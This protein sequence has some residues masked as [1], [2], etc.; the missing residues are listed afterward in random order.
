M[1]FQ[2]SKLQITEPKYWSNFTSMDHLAAM[3]NYQPEY[4]NQT[5]EYLYDVNY[6][7]NFGSMI[8][9]LPV[10]YIDNGEMNYRWAM[11]GGEERPIPLVKA[12][13]DAAGT[14]LNA[15]D[16][17]G[18]YGASFYMWFAEPYFTAT[19]TLLGSKPE[20]YVIR[21][22]S[23]AIQIGDLYRHEVELL[24]SNQAFFVPVADL[25]ADSL[26]NEGWGQVEQA[27]SKRGNG[28]HHGTHF[29][30]ENT[31][32][33]IRKNYEVP[34]NVLRNGTQNNPLAFAFKDLETGQT[35]KKWI[36]K[37]AWD[38]YRQFRNDAYRLDLYGKSNKQLDGSY[39][40]KG[41]SGNVIKSGFGL[42]EQMNNS[43]ILY[44]NKFSID[45]LL[46][47]VL[48]VTV[49]KFRE[50]QRKL[51]VTCGEYGAVQFHKAL[52]AKPG[53]S[54]FFR[55]DY[56]LEKAANGKLGWN[57]G[58]FTTIKWVNGIEITLVIDSQKDSPFHTLKHPDGGNVASYIYDIFDF[59]QTNGQA[60]IMRV[61]Q[62]NFEETFGYI[63]GMFDPFTPGGK[64]GNP[65]TIT[66]SV[67]GYS[68][69][70]WKQRGI[71]IKNPLKTGRFIPAIYR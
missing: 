31:L 30:F 55:S 58:Q 41:E 7:Y 25:V 68:V 53:A 50:D 10:H 18:Q 6:G 60:N 27:L 65:K 47:F 5:L 49:G 35:S 46:D 61:M 48:S 67:D 70:G 36:D 43:N 63:P 23:D 28:I 13:L 11:I 64:A 3:G 69:Y 16:K 34:G 42:Y 15:T 24:T 44:Y 26:W 45:A 8:N 4:I 57:E 39:G 12:S 66:S 71:M 40:N 2:V 51:V 22:K 62:R 14:A 54:S 56:P 20:A 37:Q 29:M 59:G 52:L 9:K 17:P 1:G 38:F 33:V 32:N 19:T 21:C